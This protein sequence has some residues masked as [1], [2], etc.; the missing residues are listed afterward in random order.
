MKDS[1]YWE[2]RV[3]NKTWN[4]Y[5]SL[6]ERNKALK[7]IY[8]EA[9]LDIEEDLYKVAKKMET[10]TPTLSDMHKYN[11]LGKLNDNINE[12]IKQLSNEIEKRTT[13][14]ITKAF[15]ENYSNTMKEL[16][17]LEYTLPNKK[18]IES[19][20]KFP[21]SG[22]NFSSRLWENTRVLE[23]NLNEIL[24]RGLVQGKAIFEMATQ[25]EE[26]MMKGFDEAHRLVR[27]ETMHYL[28]ESSLRAYM[29]SG[30]EKIQ[31]WAALDE[32]TCHVCGVKHGNKY[33]LKDAPIVPLHA[34]CRCTYIPL[35]DEDDD[36]KDYGKIKESVNNEFN[37]RDNIGYKYTNNGIIIVTED[38]KGEH[39]SLPRKYKPYAV[40]ETDSIKKNVRQIDRTFYDKDGLMKKQIHSGPHGNSKLHPYGNNGEHCHKYKW[41]GKCERTTHE[42]SKKDRRINKD[43]L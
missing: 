43:I 42:L 17:E 16:G 39:Y 26:R 27:T 11:R 19:L 32:R 5:N 31:L 18:L 23:R 40:I 41:D 30:V 29:D 28:N 12:I 4:I 24:T 15:I 7:E 25:L 38:H 9:Y 1:N 13:N 34:N 10:G 22:D 8:Q 20:L 35:I 14:Q 33:R 21:W 36:K 37:R 2:K 3:A 6:E